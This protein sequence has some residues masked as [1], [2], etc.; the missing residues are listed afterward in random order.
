MLGERHLQHLELLKG[1]V[2]SLGEM[3][4]LIFKKTITISTGLSEVFPDKK[5][6]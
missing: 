5:I 1:Y 3:S 4:E 6:V 2:S